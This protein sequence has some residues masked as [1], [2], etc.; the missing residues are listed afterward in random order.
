MDEELV[1]GVVGALGGDFDAAVPEVADPAGE[2]E[3]LRVLEDEVAEAHALDHAGDVGMQAEVGLFGHD[4]SFCL[5]GGNDVILPDGAG[6]KK[7]GD[8]YVAPTD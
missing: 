6:M 3:V 2:V 4:R 8:M 7:A 5:V 1:H